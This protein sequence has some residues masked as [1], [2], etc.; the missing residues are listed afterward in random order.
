MATVIGS[1]ME[2]LAILDYGFY[3][4]QHDA[5]KTTAVQTRK[6]ERLREERSSPPFSAQTARANIGNPLS[7][8]VIHGFVDCRYFFG[9]PNVYVGKA[10][11]GLGYDAVAAAPHTGDDVCT[12]GRMWAL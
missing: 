6:A 12:R 5:T 11:W 4:T 3:Y 1:R 7:E 8:V 10:L 9:A 2:G